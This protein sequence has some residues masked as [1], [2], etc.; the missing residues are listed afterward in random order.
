MN[1]QSTLILCLMLI[2]A[3][4]FSNKKANKKEQQTSVSTGEY[5]ADDFRTLSPKQEKEIKK[6]IL[7]FKK[8]ETEE[9]VK[10]ISY[11]LVRD[12]P[13]P[14]IQNEV[15]MNTYFD[16]VFDESLKTEIAKSTPSD[17]SQV[18]W[19]G[20]MLNQGVVWLSD[21]A[22][23][24]TG[25]NYRSKKSDERYSKLIEAQKAAV[26]TSIAEF[27]RP[28][29]S[30]ITAS[31]MIRIDETTEGVFRYVSWKA[32]QK[33]SEKPEL[34]LNKGSVE[35]SGSGGNCV[36]IFRSGKYIYRVFRNIM[37]EGYDKAVTLSVEKEG[38]V[39]L[40]EDG[41]LLSESF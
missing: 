2:G 32:G 34:V 33:Q 22:T 23:T 9:I 30:S 19:R 37:G 11:P 39:I 28:I 21:D 40:K 7:L 36:Y 24:I 14:A 13:I 18:G 5:D 35:Y 27:K 17:W 25:I 10:R 29:F 16:E 31:Y 26:H 6:F 38:M 15:E 1:I 41:D 3:C 20:I 12:F 4:T 8:N